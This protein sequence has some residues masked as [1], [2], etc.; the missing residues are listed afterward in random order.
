MQKCELEPGDYV[1][2]RFRD[3]QAQTE[4]KSRGYILVFRKYGNEDIAWI[5][6]KPGNAWVQIK[7]VFLPDILRRLP[8]PLKRGEEHK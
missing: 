4:R 6:D 1:E 2:Y 3:W 7:S 8:K 5:G